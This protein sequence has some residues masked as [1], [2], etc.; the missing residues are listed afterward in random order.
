MIPVE[1]FWKEYHKG[2]HQEPR[3]LVLVESSDGPVQDFA[4]PMTNH[5]KNFF[6][7]PRGVMNKIITHV[8]VKK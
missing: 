2:K 3:T 1:K 8:L 7:H 4:Y 5:G 6:D